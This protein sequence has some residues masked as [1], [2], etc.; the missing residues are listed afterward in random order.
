MGFNILSATAAN[1]PII[2]VAYRLAVTGGGAPTGLRPYQSLTLA[3]GVSVQLAA[4]GA[5][6]L[7]ILNAGPGNVYVSTTST[8]GANAQSTLI[9]PFKTVPLAATTGSLWMT[10]DQDGTIASVALTPR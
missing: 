9:P 8:P 2:A 10:S 1:S 7:S 4:A 5:Y 6:Q 3:A